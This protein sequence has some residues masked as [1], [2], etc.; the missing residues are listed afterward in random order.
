MVAGFKRGDQVE[1][2]FPEG[3]CM[4]GCGRTDGYR[5][6]VIGDPEERKVTAGLVRVQRSPDGVKFYE[7]PR[8]VRKVDG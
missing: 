1:V 3:R 4:C 5:G 7:Y 2:S 8:C 6:V